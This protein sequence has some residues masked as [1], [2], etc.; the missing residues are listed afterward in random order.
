MITQK[1]G[2]LTSTLKDLREKQK[3]AFFVLVLQD[4][5]TNI[6]VEIWKLNTIF[7]LLVGKLKENEYND[8]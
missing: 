3:N 4:V 2:I 1:I 7:A 8:Y 6:Y 5:S